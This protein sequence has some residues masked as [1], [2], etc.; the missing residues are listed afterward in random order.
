MDED[1]AQEGSGPFTFGLR[2]ESLGGPLFNDPSLIHE[3]DPV[4]NLLCKTHFVRD[5]HHR[6]ALPSQVS[7]DFEDF[8]DHFRI[9]CGSGFVKEHDFRLHRQRPGNGHP[10][11][12]ASGE[13][14]RIAM[15]LFRN[16]D[17]GHQVVGDLF[18][19][20]PGLF[21]DL[22]RGQDDI[23]E[24]GLMRIKVELLED[25]SHLGPQPGDV[26]FWVIQGHPV[27]DDIAALDQFQPVDATDERALSRTARSADHD[28]LPWMNGEIDILQDLE[29]PEP[30]VH[31]PEFNHNGRPCRF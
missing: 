25:H 26:G 31:F 21:S 24:S 30:F 9:Q 11:L 19:L 13:L 14:G 16:S 2:K 8:V 27:D 10:L 18:G 12:L 7:H 5:D 15:D 28:D 4:R 20:F 3:D 29:G 17:L 6:H 23:F 1:L 22:H